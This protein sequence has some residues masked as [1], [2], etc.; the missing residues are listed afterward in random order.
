MVQGQTTSGMRHVAPWCTIDRG[1]VASA[2]MLRTRGSGAKSEKRHKNWVCPLSYASPPLEV[3][4]CCGASLTQVVVHELGAL[5]TSCSP[6]HRA[7]ALQ[8]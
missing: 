2:R 4:A 6:Q 7:R 1:H 3:R 8:A 5:H